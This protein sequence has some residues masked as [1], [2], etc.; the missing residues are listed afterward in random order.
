MRQIGCFAAANAG[1]C[2]A[3]LL[4]GGRLGACELPK[5]SDAQPLSTIR[6][7]EVGHDLRA[8]AEL[9]PVVEAEPDNSE[10]AWLLSKALSELGEF[11]SALV[12]A[13]RAVSLDRD[14]AAYHVQLG[15]ILGRMAEKASMFTQLGLARRTRK[16]LETALTLDPNNLDGLYGL[17]LYYFSAPSFLGGDKSK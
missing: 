13:E 16:E 10:A 5:R 7:L 12:F 1:F 4:R 3:G 6:L 11:D 2:I 9:T 15:A 8:K 17:M 14:N